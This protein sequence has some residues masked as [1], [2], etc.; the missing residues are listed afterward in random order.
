MTGPHPPAKPQSA[1]GVFRRNRVARDGPIG[2]FEKP[3]VE[4]A[5]EGS[6][7][8][9]DAFST[10]SSRLKGR[11]ENGRQGEIM[12]SGR[13]FGAGLGK[14]E[15]TLRIQ[16]VVRGHWGRGEARWWLNEMWNQQGDID[17]KNELEAGFY[18]DGGESGVVAWGEKEYAQYSEHLRQEGTAALHAGELETALDWFSQA[19]DYDSSNFEVSVCCLCLSVGLML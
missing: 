5:A 9:G 11:I 6:I 17:F 13:S 12:I 1:H 3:S 14:A 8:V 10:S 19:L 18:D 16:R 4:D 15:A 7:A 2:R